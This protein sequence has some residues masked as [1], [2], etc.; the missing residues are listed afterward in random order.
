MFHCTF[1]LPRVSSNICLFLC[2]A[3]S[4][5]AGIWRKKNRSYGYIAIY[6]NIYGDIWLYLVIYGYIRS[7]LHPGIKE[8]PATLVDQQGHPVVKMDRSLEHP[9]I[10]R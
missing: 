8:V 9:V 4:S 6:I 3:S 5:V 10:S 1:D 7:Q 2:H